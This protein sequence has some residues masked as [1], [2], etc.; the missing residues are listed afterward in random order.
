MMSWTSG[1]DPAFVAMLT[2]GCTAQ[3]PAAQATF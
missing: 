1:F 3:P 2:E